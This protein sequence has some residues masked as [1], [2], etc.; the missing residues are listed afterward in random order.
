[1]QARDPHTEDPTNSGYVDV[2]SLAID[3][4]PHLTIPV[5]GV[6]SAGHS[7]PYALYG[8]DWLPDPLSTND[9]A[10]RFEASLEGASAVSFDATRMNVDPHQ[11][12]S[13][14]ITTDGPATVTM[15]SFWP[16]KGS[17][18]CDCG[19]SFALGWN[20]TTT[21]FELTEAGTWTLSATLDPSGVGQPGDNGSGPG[22]AGGD[23]PATGG[24][25]VAAALAGL[26]ATSQLGR[27]RR[28]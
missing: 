18:S 9:V 26:A 19:P 12:M 2:T 7:T 27:A 1:L 16:G 14:T 22:N 4:D 23:M 6:A 21:S 5:A 24:G 28:A 17:L 3:E 11:Q 15:T 13:A 20:G 8:L 10:N 25:L